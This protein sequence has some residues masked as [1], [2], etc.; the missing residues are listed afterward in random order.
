MSIKSNPH[1]LSDPTEIPS[2]GRV[3]LSSDSLFTL[4]LE[5]EIL[6]AART[7]GNQASLGNLV[8]CIMVNCLRQLDHDQLRQMARDIAARCG[9]EVIDP[10]EKPLNPS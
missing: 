3:G 6:I 2:S 9:L 5:Q 8:P 7:M 4:E 1:Q 10:N